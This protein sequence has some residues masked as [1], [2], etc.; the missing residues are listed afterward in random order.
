MPDDDRLPK[1]LP[2]RWRAVARALERGDDIDALSEL[3]EKAIAATIRNIGG[4]PAINEISDQAHRAASARC[5]TLPIDGLQV[6]LSAKRDRLPQTDLAWGRARVLVETRT[7]E[8]AADA[9]SARHKVA[10]SVVR[11]LA[12]HF[13]FGRIVPELIDRAPWTA[14]DLHE[15][16][17]QVLAQPGVDKLAASLL[18]RPDGQDIQAPRRRRPS[19]ESLLETSVE[20]L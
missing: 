4:V 13:G 18:R 7:E 2:P 20:D 16:C 10:V 5:D 6:G 9:A 15:R 17:V 1:N 3:T 11:A 8:L 12:H 14:D 19:T